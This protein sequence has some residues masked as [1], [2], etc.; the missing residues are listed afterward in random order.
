M[1]NTNRDDLASLG[2]HSSLNELS[3]TDVVTFILND[4]TNKSL[5][6]WQKM[7]YQMTRRH[8]ISCTSKRNKTKIQFGTWFKHKIPN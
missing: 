6:R 7:G 8:M 1:A 2:D 4:Y 3:R 5:N